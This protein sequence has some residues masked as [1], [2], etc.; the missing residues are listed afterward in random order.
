LVPLAALCP[1]SAPDTGLDKAQASVFRADLL[2]T[3]HREE[4]VPL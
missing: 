4:P 2:R 1:P 3:T